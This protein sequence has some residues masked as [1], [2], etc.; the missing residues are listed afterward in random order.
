MEFGYGFDV[1]RLVFETEIGRP[2]M[3]GNMLTKLVEP[4]HIRFDAA[5][6][7]GKK[8]KTWRI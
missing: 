6:N 2:E 4:M 3:Y 8:L 5:L 7:A 1:W